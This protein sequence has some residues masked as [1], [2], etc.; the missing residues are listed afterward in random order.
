MGNEVLNSAAR[1]CSDVEPPFEVFAREEAVCGA[2]KIMGW[3]GRRDE[4]KQ[5]R[6]K[7]A[8]KEKVAAANA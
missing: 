5:R 2:R 8:G 4:P 1:E 6:E 7:A 3:H